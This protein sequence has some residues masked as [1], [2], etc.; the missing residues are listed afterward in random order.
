MYNAFQIGNF[1]HGLAA[2]KPETRRLPIIEV[3]PGTLVF[4]KNP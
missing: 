2:I 1:S 3:R 4:K